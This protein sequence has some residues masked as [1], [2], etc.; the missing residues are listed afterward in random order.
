MKE[1]VDTGV[2]GGGA[3]GAVEGR[4]GLGRGGGGKLFVTGWKEEVVGKNN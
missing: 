1:E 3:R 4:I 2:S